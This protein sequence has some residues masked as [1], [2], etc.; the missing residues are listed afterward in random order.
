[1]AVEMAV[2]SVVGTGE[3]LVERLVERMDLA[4]AAMRVV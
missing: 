4:W 3:D 1:M 2:S